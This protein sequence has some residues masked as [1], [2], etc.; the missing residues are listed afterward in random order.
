M[1]ESVEEEDVE[2]SD[3][4]NDSNHGEPVNIVTRQYGG[5]L[6]SRVENGS[7]EII[8]ETSAEGY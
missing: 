1:Q 8:I 6:G 5:F 3:C 2:A 7:D 4:A